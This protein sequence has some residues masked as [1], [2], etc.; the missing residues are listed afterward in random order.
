MI[1]VLV[2]T[3]NQV[4]KF[5]SGVMGGF[6]NTH[7]AHMESTIYVSVIDVAH[8]TVVEFPKLSV[9]RR[10]LLTIYELI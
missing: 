9:V 10:P 3:I 5:L 4:R 1:Y 6:H 8:N 2:S 7:I